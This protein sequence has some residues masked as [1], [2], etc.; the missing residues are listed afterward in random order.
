[1]VWT[2]WLRPP[3][4]AGRLSV[5][6][7]G[8]AGAC[9][10]RSRARLTGHGDDPGFAQGLS[11][12]PGPGARGLVVAGWHRVAETR[13]ALALRLLLLQQLVRPEVPVLLHRLR[14][15]AER[16][17]SQLVSQDLGRADL[18]LQGALRG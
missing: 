13:L 5:L 8:R 18:R 1:M 15:E 2:V 3:R 7:N 9:C 17:P 12:Q 10:G 11:L 4:N 14:V 6:R 16:E